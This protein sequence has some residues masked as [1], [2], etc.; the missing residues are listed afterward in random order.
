MATCDESRRKWRIAL[1][2]R[3]PSQSLQCAVTLGGDALDGKYR[4]TV[5]AGDSPDAYNDID[6][7]NRV[8][9]QTTNLL[10]VGGSVALPPHS[11]TVLEVEKKP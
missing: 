8:T 1:V 5:L 4:A 3:H 10:F 7:P 6:A 11:V 9:P 2:N